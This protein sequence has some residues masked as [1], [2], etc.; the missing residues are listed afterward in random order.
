MVIGG[1]KRWLS[2]SWAP[3]KQR[4][5]IIELLY[6]GSTY[7]HKVAVPIKRKGQYDMINISLEQGQ[8]SIICGHLVSARAEA[9]RGTSEA[10][11]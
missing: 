6:I 11:C 1:G 8:G 7:L 9:S 2:L 5:W 4:S 3:T 10:N